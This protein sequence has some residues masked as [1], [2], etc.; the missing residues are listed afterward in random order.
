VVLVSL[1]VVTDRLLW[2]T[3]FGPIASRNNFRRLQRG[4]CTASGRTNPSL[5][6]WSSALLHRGFAE[7]L[8]FFVLLSSSAV[9]E[10]RK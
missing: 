10:I 4:Q 3:V 7:L 1:D 8:L 9:E 5:L 6:P 2:K